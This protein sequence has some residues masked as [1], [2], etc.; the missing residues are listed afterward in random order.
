MGASM[1]RARRVVLCG[2]LN[3]SIA[4][5]AMSLPGSAQAEE[6]PAPRAEARPAPASPAG[7]KPEAASGEA[8]SKPAVAAADPT[9]FALQGDGNG[10]PAPAPT[11]APPIPSPHVPSWRQTGSWGW[12]VVV[13]SVGLGVATT[14]YGLTLRCADDDTECRRHTSLAIWGGVGIASVG[15]TFGILIVQ[16]GQA[17][18]HA[19]PAVFA[20]DSR[21]HAEARVRP[22][23]PGL[24][25]DGQF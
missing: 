6:P 3:A 25:L 14:A 1:S 19:K 16:I 13:T 2:A 9:M 18:V 7:P 23:V 12:L 21:S 8:R 10:N 17:R 5:V 15:A 4:L 24:V 11:V 22:L 20:G